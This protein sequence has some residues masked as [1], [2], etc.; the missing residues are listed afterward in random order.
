MYEVASES[1]ECDKW[2]AVGGLE[3]GPAEDIDQRVL[4]VLFVVL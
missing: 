4:Q 2:S 1:V 3:Q